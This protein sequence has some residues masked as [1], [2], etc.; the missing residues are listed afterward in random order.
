M[1]ARVRTRAK[2]RA[3]ARAK[4]RPRSASIQATVMLHSSRLPRRPSRQVKRLRRHMMS[5]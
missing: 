5:R 2:A 4:E 1:K 3:K